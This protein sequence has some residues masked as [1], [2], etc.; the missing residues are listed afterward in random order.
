MCTCM[1][2]FPWIRQHDLFLTHT[3][4][5][6]TFFLKEQINFPLPSHLFSSF[7]FFLLEGG[8][9]VPENIFLYKT[10]TILIFIVIVYLYEFCVNNL[11]VLVGLFYPWHMLLNQMIDITKYTQTKITFW[12]TMHPR[13]NHH[14]DVM[15]GLSWITAGKIRKGTYKFHIS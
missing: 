9:V 14:L 5:C 6:H 4:I 2:I 8:S 11:Y 7:P 12:K 3:N 15:S 1:G 10:A 13:P